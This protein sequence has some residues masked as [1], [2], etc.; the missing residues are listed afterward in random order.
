MPVT[1]DLS[2]LKSG[3]KTEI[4]LALAGESRQ[5]VVLLLRED[6]LPMVQIT[7]GDGLVTN[8]VVS[9]VDLLSIL[10]RSSNISQ[11]EQ[12]QTR[13]TDLPLLPENTLFVSVL[14]RPEGR[15]IALTGYVEPDTYVVVLREKGETRT[16]DIPL[17]HIVYR[18]VHDE[19]R[20]ALSQLSMTLANPGLRPTQ[21]GAG[22]RHSAAPDPGTPTF[23]WPMSNVYHS[24]GGASEGVCWPGI[25]DV[26]MT[27]PGIPEEAVKRFVRTENNAD[28]YG[29]GLSHNAP[30]EGYAEFLAAMEE[31]GGIHEDYLIP[32]GYTV[33]DLHHQRAAGSG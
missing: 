2:L 7:T 28:L 6:R 4:E 20:G 21:C 1:R 8:K 13:T 33:E 23:R 11:L 24:F 12:A 5:S 29:R 14:E 9:L 25:R 32:T 19:R 10:D 15:K 17:P 22:G 27:L 18:A 26:P 3:L 30:Y 16:F 31:E